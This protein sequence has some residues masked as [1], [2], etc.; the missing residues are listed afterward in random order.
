MSQN[1]SDKVQYREGSVIKLDFTPPRYEVREF[2]ERRGGCK[3]EEPCQVIS[4]DDY[5]VERTSNN[6]YATNKSTSLEDELKYKSLELRRTRKGKN[7]K[8]LIKGLIEKVSNPVKTNSSSNIVDL[9]RRGNRN[10]REY[11]LLEELESARELGMF[12]GVLDRREVKD[13]I[14]EQL[15][16]RFG[17]DLKPLHYLQHEELSYLGLSSQYYLNNS[18]E[19]RIEGGIN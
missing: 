8:K 18:L 12:D 6:E 17:Y 10:Q 13:Y 9:S 5:R 1:Y 11:A 19:S 15:Q 4:V 3:R 16:S 7:A 2:E 14:W